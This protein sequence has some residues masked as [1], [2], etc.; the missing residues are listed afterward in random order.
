[1]ERTS[2]KSSQ[3]VSVGYDPSILTLEVEFR[4]FRAD[5]T[6]TTVWQYTNVPPKLYEEMM[7]APSTGSFFH[8]NIKGQF[9]ANR[10]S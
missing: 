7:R 10:V 8:K 1:M 3:I 2:V 9:S 4:P 5:T 6:A